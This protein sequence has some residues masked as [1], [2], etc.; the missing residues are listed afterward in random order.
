M[1]AATWVR[2]IKATS[3]PGGRAARRAVGSVAS[4]SVG[5]RVTGDF[6]GPVG[7]VL[8]PLEGT[9]DAGQPFGQLVQ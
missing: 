5:K 3:R 6:V 4:N 9:L 7:A 2:F 1:I 8:E